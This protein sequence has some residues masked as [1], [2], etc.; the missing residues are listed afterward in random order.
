MQKKDAKRVLSLRKGA[1]KANP[2]CHKA[3]FFSTAGDQTQFLALVAQEVA[4]ECSHLSSPLST[5]KVSLYFV[6]YHETSLAD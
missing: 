1:L 5:R 3:N 2:S 6:P 4:C